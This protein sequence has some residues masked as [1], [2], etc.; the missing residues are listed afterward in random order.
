M[1]IKKI[2]FCHYALFCFI[3]FF[4]LNNKTQK[5]EQPMWIARGIEGY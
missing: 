5:S 4:C 1:K 3:L 2:K